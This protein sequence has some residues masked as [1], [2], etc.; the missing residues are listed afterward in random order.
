M[1][2]LQGA[3]LAS[4]AGCG[5]EPPKS[6]LFVPGSRLADMSLGFSTP[7]WPNRPKSWDS[8]GRNLEGIKH[9]LPGLL[10]GRNIS[11][12]LEAVNGG[13]DWKGRVKPV[14]LDR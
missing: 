11:I 10:N 7:K 9:V 13:R 14:S 5:V 3:A 12:H 6:I 8:V 2:L 1:S 4:T